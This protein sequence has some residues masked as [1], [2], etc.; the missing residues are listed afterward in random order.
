MK[1][2]KFCLLCAI[3]FAMACSKN[4]DNATT[5][6]DFCDPSTGNFMNLFIRT[7][8]KPYLEFVKGDEGH[9]SKIKMY[10]Y[11]ATANSVSYASH[12]TS[13]LIYKK[14]TEFYG[15]TTYNDVHV[16]GDPNCCAAPLSTISIKTDKDFDKGHPA[17]SLI[18]DLFLISYP[19]YHQYI[20]NGYTPKVPR[21]SYALDSISELSDFKNV[22]LFAANTQLIFKETPAPGKYTFTVTLDFGEDPLTGEKVTVPPANI[23]IEF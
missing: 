7:P 11:S 6:G 15:D 8:D 13:L 1:R 19:R 10:L 2:I 18:N 23:E 9:S 5:S 21:G 14:Y 20:K 22:S 16:I 12:D 4:D 3:L 17:G